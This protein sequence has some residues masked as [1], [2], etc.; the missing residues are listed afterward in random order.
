MME[1]S[2]STM[3]ESIYTGWVGVDRLRFASCYMGDTC[4]IHGF[5][6]SGHY[7][8]RLRTMAYVDR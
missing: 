8:C 4:R 2:I 3:V 6:L 5:P 1:Q 7:P